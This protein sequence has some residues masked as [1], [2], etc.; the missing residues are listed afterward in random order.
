MCPMITVKCNMM[1]K[2]FQIHLRQMSFI[3]AIQIK[4]QRF[5]LNK[6]MDL[7]QDKFT[8]RPNILR[9][10]MAKT[11]RLIMQEYMPKR[12]QRDT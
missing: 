10:N 9:K 3:I 11:Q 2:S 8:K 6:F 5:L 4:I 12:K 7:N 1:T